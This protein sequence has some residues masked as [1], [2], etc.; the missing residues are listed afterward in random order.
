MTYFGAEN[1]LGGLLNHVVTVPAGDGD[2]SN[3]LGVE[4]DLLDE[5]GRLLD[6][7]VESILG[8]L[9]IGSEIEEKR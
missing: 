8:P 3:L 1:L 9:I 6:D 2:E 7:F 5:V 4:A